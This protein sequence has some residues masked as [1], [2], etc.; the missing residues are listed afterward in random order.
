MSP[1]TSQKNRSGSIGVDD[2]N[3]LLTSTE[4]DIGRPRTMST[5]NDISRPRTMSTENDVVRQRTMSTDTDGGRQLLS[6]LEMEGRQQRSNSA[7]SFASTLSLNGDFCKICHCGGEPNT[8]LITPCFCS[9]S[10][11]HVHQVTIFKRLFCAYHSVGVKMRESFGVSRKFF[12]GMRENIGGS[13][14][15]F[16]FLLHFPHLWLHLK[17]GRRS[18]KF[19][20]VKSVSNQYLIKIIS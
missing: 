8:P 13:P 2:S 9:G 10:L 14:I 6:T 12:L 17:E 5:E 18:F 1:S 19:Q 16:I 11:K 15:Y 4:N 7:T 3:K 20:I